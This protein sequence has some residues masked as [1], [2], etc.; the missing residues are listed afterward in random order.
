MPM[1]NVLIPFDRFTPATYMIMAAII[2]AVLG[3]GFLIKEI[4][5]ANQE[6]STI[7][8]PKEIVVDTSRID[9]L[10]I[11]EYIRLTNREVGKIQSRAD[12][13]IIYEKDGGRAYYKNVLVIR[14]GQ[15]YRLPE[16]VSQAILAT[17]KADVAQY[18]ALYDRLVE[19]L[20]SDL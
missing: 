10:P 13:N 1:P 9:I 19:E 5:K 11:F 17:I 12:K 8:T 18:E 3:G 14:N 20:L 6:S 7:Q 16:Q 2:L 4:R 15:P